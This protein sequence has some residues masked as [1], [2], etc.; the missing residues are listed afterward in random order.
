MN[1][2]CKD[3]A[4]W[5][6][7]DNNYNANRAITITNK[8]INTPCLLKKL[9]KTVV[10]SEFIYTFANKYLDINKN[11]RPD[12]VEFNFTDEGHQPFAGDAQGRVGVPGRGSTDYMEQF[13]MPMLTAIVPAAVNLIAPVSDAFVNQIDLDNNTMQ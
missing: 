12:G 10:F 6:D 4:F 3:D 7:Y 1:V 9:Q 2:K 8:K 11:I 5:D 13:V